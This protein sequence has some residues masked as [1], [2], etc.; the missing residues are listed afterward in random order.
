MV[1][2]IPANRDT[3]I[4]VDGR[5]RGK[6]TSG[7]SESPWRSLLSFPELPADRFS[8]RANT[9]A[10]GQFAPRK[11]TNRAKTSPIHK[12]KK[13]LISGLA[14]RAECVYVPRHLRP[15]HRKYRGEVPEW[16][17]G[18]VSKTVERAS[19][20]RV[21]IPLSPPF[22]IKRYCLRRELSH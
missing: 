9:S 6:P 21:R 4:G 10:G 18:A 2:T 15:V 3:L 1:T 8:R 16:L 22:S 12:L 7:Q 5:Y 20:P 14:G 11:P 19:V 17:N 13:E